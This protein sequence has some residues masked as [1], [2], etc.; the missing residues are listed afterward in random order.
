MAPPEGPCSGYEVAAYVCYPKLSPNFTCA[1]L[2]P[3]QCF[4]DA[5][6]C[7]LQAVADEVC[8]RI[9]ESRNCCMMVA[10]GCPVG[11]PFIVD[12]TA[13]LAPL[14]AGAGW[15][16]LAD[17][18]HPSTAD[19]DDATRQALAEFWA[20]EALTE[21]A[22]IASFSR[23][24]LQLLAL[25]APSDLIEDATRAATDEHGHARAAFAFASAYAGRPFGPSKLDIT[26]AISTTLTAADIAVAIASEG[27]VAE[28][29]SALQIRAASC[30]AK[31]P[32]IRAALERIAGEEMAHAELAW[33]TL[34]WL[35][36]NG[37]ARMRDEVERVFF[38]ATAHV[39]I[40]PVVRSPGDAI[41]MRDH[42]YLAPD[43]RRRLAASAI[44]EVITPSAKALMASLEPGAACTS[45]SV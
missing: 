7:G 31:D 28:T 11:R 9:D 35:L 15:D 14:R 1:E 25:G 44:R 4:L 37:D 43:E 6:S 18:K 21:H 2:Y 45:A 19:L 12:G 3:P 30:S 32:A 16:A 39:G 17:A 34:R 41:K 5:F 33:R 29:V 8:G 22:S 36:A 13:R 26:G 20:K 38:G 40:G 27:C 24:V 23:F 10:G 42:G